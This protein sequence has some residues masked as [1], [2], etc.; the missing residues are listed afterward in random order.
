MVQFQPTVERSDKGSTSIYVP[1]WVLH[2]VAASPKVEV[3]GYIRDAGDTAEWVE[4]PN[5]SPTPEHKFSFPEPE[6]ISDIIGIWHSHPSGSLVP[7]EADVQLFEVAGVN[8]GVV[9]TLPA[10]DAVVAG[11]W[12]RQSMGWTMSNSGAYPIDNV[13]EPRN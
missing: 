8:I 4:V 3:C 2:S 6:G 13:N 1:R 12:T 9:L 5:E 10:D 7:T 11:F